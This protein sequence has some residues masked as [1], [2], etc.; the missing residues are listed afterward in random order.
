[1]EGEKSETEKLRNSLI[2]GEIIHCKVIN[3]NKHG[4]YF[5]INWIKT[6]IN[7]AKTSSK[8]P[9]LEKM[10]YTQLLNK[11]TFRL[12]LILMQTYFCSEIF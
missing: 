9:S 3:Y 12:Q 8:E 1:M 7:H 2:D 10:T 6:S 5:I 4:S 11:S